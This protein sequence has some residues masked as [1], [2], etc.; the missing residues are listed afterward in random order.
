MIDWIEQHWLLAFCAL[1]GIVAAFGLA[2]Q[3]L[4]AVLSEEEY[5]PYF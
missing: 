5:D 2:W 1:S 3:G 4:V